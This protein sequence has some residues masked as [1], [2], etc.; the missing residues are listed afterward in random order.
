MYLFLYYEVC[1]LV[2][3]NYFNLI[4]YFRFKYWVYN[5]VKYLEGEFCCLY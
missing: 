5:Y 4:R 3:V 2:D 1:E